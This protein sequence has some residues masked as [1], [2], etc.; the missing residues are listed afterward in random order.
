MA[1]RLISCFQECQNGVS[2]FNPTDSLFAISDFFLRLEHHFG[3]ANEFLWMHPIFST[4]I[5]VE[6]FEWDFCG[7]LH[8][9][10]GFPWAQKIYW[11]LISVK[12]R[13]VFGKCDSSISDATFYYLS[14]NNC[15]EFNNLS[16]LT[17]IRK[18]NSKLSGWPT[19]LR[20]HLIILFSKM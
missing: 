16:Y 11:K 17:V 14:T 15:I 20:N 13:I 5:S 12:S 3:I 19:K 2:R 8:F 10:N 1:L 7:N 4:S 9:M 6:H 18:I